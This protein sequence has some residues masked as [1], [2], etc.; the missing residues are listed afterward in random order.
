MTIGA[1]ETAAVG[2]SGSAAVLTGIET[3][4]V[5]MGLGKGA[6]VGVSV[7]ILDDWAVVYTI[8]LVLTSVSSNIGVTLGL[9]IMLWAG[10]PG[11]AAAGVE[12]T[13]VVAPWLPCES[14]PRVFMIASA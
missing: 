12:S 6:A 14:A 3:S 7:T 13:L 10:T 9:A 11:E 5:R 2:I 8:G 1:V 4:G